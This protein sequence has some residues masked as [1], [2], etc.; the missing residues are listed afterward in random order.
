[1][2]EVSKYFQIK[3]NDIRAE[4]FLENFRFL[5]KYAPE[6]SVSLEKGQFFDKIWA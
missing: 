6:S 5:T 4:S 1:M 3:K 2:Q